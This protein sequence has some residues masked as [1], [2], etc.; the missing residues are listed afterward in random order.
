MIKGLKEDKNPLANKK[1]K[2]VVKQSRR[3]SA[4]VASYYAQL[5]ESAKEDQKIHKRLISLEETREEREAERSKVKDSFY[6]SK[7]YHASKKT[8]LLNLQIEERRLIVAQRK[9]ELA[10]ATAQSVMQGLSQQP[11]G[12]AGSGN[13]PPQVYLIKKGNTFQ[14][15][16]K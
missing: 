15:S 7:T 4:P 11:G 10:Q 12:G 2:I 5:I 16:I 14:A 6:E 9:M 8:E 1:P 3:H 13:K